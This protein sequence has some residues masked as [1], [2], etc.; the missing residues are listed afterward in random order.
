MKT[1]RVL[2][3][4]VKSLKILKYKVQPLAEIK[5]GEWKGI[6]LKLQ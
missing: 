1:L 6:T 5:Y 4:I 2:K 3:D